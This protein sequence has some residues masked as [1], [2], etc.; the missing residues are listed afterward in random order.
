MAAETQMQPQNVA[1]DPAKAMDSV[2]PV[3]AVV[4]SPATSD[5]QKETR[6]DTK[7]ARRAEKK[8]VVAR[9]PEAAPTRRPIIPNLKM[10]S[11]SAPNQNLAKLGEASA[12]AADITSAATGGAVPPAG[13]LTSVGRISNPPAPAAPVLAAPAPAPAVKTVREPKLISSTRAVYPA[14]AR[15]SSIQG[16]VTVSASIDANGKVVA[17]KA[18][19]GPILLRQAAVDSVSQWKYSPGLIDGKPAPSQVNVSVEF[20]MN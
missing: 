14:T 5:S 17:A 1:T 6:P 20:R 3:P 16:S 4:T 9:Q 2:A 7:N 10:S 13:L 19:S 15:Q 12:P 11:P 18:L 8:E